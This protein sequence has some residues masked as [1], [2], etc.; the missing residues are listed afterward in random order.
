MDR[1]SNK[2]LQIEY[3]YI[4]SIIDWLTSQITVT[5]STNT[6][7]YVALLP[8]SGSWPSLAGLRDQAQWTHE[9]GFPWTR[10]QPDADTLPDDTQHP[11]LSINIIYFIYRISYFRVTCFDSYCRHGPTHPPTSTPT[12][13]H[14]HTH[15]HTHTHTVHTYTINDPK[16][17]FAMDIDTMF[18]RVKTSL[19]ERS[20]AREISRDIP[21]KI[22]F[23]LE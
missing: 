10:D 19:S 18:V 1:L 4:C 17:T 11:K 16:R 21:M 13:P 9:V 6:L 20:P 12:H 7:S 8:D 22:G 14:P 15:T 3:I 23:L 2:F 5:L